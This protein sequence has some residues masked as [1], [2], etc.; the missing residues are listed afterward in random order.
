MFGELQKIDRPIFL[1]PRAV[2]ILL[3]QLRARVSLAVPYCAKE[4][5]CDSCIGVGIA[6]AADGVH[7]ALH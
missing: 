6:S 5:A 4:C 3:P 1:R 2:N 7:D